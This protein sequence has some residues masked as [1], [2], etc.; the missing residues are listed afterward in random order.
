MDPICDHLDIAFTVIAGIRA[1]ICQSVQ[2]LPGLYRNVSK[3]EVSMAD[4]VDVALPAH[5]QVAAER[6]GLTV[7]RSVTSGTWVRRLPR[8]EAEIAVECLRD[9]GFSA[10]IVDIAFE[11]AR[12][13]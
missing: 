1:V 4:L 13:L 12:P 2:Q 10:R 11:E 8:D 3:G 7:Q 9:F 6:L 5:A